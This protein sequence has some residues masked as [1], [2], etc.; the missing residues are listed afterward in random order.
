QGRVAE[1]TDWARRLLTE[2]NRSGNIDLQILG[3]RASLSS[4]F[5][6]GEL[7]EALEERDK[8]LALYDEKQA[9]HWRGLTG[10]DLRTAVG[11]MSSQALWMLGYPAQASQ[12]SDQWEADS[13]RLGHPFHIRSAPPRT[14]S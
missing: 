1:S 13:V 8:A 2:G 11:V 4:H 6:V 12:M 3:H 14:A 7:S 5:Y 10:I 9:A